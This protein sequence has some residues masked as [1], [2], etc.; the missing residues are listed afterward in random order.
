LGNVPEQNLLVS[1]FCPASQK[2]TRLTLVNTRKRCGLIFGVP[3]ECN[4]TYSCD[5]CTWMD[6]PKCLLKA[7]KITLK[8][9]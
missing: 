5:G 2:L 7:V 3:A 6:N 4:R 8:Q 9:R 1:V